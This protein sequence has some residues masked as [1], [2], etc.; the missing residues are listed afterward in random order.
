MENFKRLK[1]GAGIFKHI[2]IYWNLFSL[3]L[4]HNGTGTSNLPDIILGSMHISEKEVTKAI[5]KEK[6]LTAVANR[7]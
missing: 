4:A 5:K 7:P 3:F 6:D 2:L 1:N